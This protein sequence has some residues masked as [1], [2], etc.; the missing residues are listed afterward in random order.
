MGSQGNAASVSRSVSHR[1]RCPPPAAASAHREFICAAFPHYR[2]ATPLHRAAAR[3]HSQRERGTQKT[4][5][6]RER[7]GRNKA[8]RFSL[9]PWLCG[10]TQPGREAAQR[11]G[12]GLLL[13]AVSAFCWQR[14]SLQ[15]AVSELLLPW[16]EKKFQL[17]EP[18]RELRREKLVRPPP[19]CLRAPLS[20]PC[21]PVCVHLHTF[22]RARENPQFRL[23]GCNGETHI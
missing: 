8:K 5:R 20:C 18:Y 12:S 19:R 1:Q 21:P 2:Q 4:G 14:G 16:A 9:R 22:Q 6:G 7:R 23:T 10:R 3:T 15:P 17:S 13:K 11:S